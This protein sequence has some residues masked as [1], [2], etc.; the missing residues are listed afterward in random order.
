[1][2]DANVIVQLWQDLQ[3]SVHVHLT[4]C[5]CI[6][7]VLFE[8]R[9]SPDLDIWHVLDTYHGPT[10]HCGSLDPLLQNPKHAIETNDSWSHVHASIS[11]VLSEF[12]KHTAPSHHQQRRAWRR[13][14]HQSA[15][16]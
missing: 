15:A 4:V 11:S 5:V 16:C 1:M 13:Q 8:M 9:E 7:C 2:A 10:C 3:G 14:Q 6:Y 12:G